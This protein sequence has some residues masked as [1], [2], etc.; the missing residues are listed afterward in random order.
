MEPISRLPGLRDETIR[1][2]ATADSY[3]RGRAYYQEGAVRAIRPVGRGVLEAFVQ[4]SAPLPY[5]VRLRYDEHGITEARCTCPYHA[6]AWCKHIV[7]VALACLAAEKRQSLRDVL[8]GLEA[9][10]LL[11]LIERLVED[12][13]LLA[14]RVKAEVERLLRGE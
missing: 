3:E 2:R 1:A 5:T 13:P 9:P 10:A 6:G 7:A 8:A 4:G 12:D 11:L 14:E